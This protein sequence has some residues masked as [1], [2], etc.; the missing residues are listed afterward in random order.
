M[1]LFIMR[2]LAL[3]AEIQLCVLKNRVQGVGLNINYTNREIRHSLKTICNAMDAFKDSIGEYELCIKECQ[4]FL[5]STQNSGW[6]SR[7]FI[8]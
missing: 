5:E 1:S 6:F 4:A 3:A 8:P 7:E 2:P